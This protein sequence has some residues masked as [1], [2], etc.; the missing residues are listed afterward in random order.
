MVL[1]QVAVMT[2][3]G[4]AIGLAVAVAA[5]RG[6]E[7]LLYQLKGWDPIVLAASAIALA[8]VALGAGLVPAHRASRLDPMRALRYE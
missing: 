7:S 3:I 8:L 2:L 5:G 6:A 4:G 1:R